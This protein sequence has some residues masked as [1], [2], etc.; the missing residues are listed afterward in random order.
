MNIFWLDTDLEK[1]ASYHV[2]KHVVKMP[3]E[4]AQMLSVVAEEHGIEVEYG[5][6]HENHPCTRWV[7]YKG[8]NYTLLY[9][10]AIAVGKEYTYRYGKYHKATRYIV[11]KLPRVLGSDTD[12]EISPLPNGTS[13]KEELPHLNLVDKYRL[14]YLRDKAHILDW[15]HR[16]EP[17]FVGDRFYMQQLEVLKDCPGNPKSKPKKE[18]KATKAQLAESIGCLALEKLTVG[19]LSKVTIEPVFV[20]EIPTGR[21]KAPYVD[22]CKEIINKDVNWTKLTVSD[23]ISVLN[24]VERKFDEHKSLN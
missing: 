4:Y 6:T 1:C 21:L 22:K 20:G 16:E 3:T 5:R 13:I 12:N 15:K 19:D 24:A 18:R 8:G 9:D 14:F 10:L 11:E 17:P 7:R 23:M 2:D